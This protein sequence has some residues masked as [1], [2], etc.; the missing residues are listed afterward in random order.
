MRFG[1]K[2]KLCAQFIG[3]CDIHERV[4]PVA[5]KL[6]LQPQLDKICNLFHVSMLT[7]YRSN[8]SNVFLV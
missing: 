2:G 8:L 7:R 6:A 3:P 5:Y 1:Q 4:E